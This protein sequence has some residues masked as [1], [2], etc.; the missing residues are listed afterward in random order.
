MW[1]AKKYPDVWQGW[2]QALEVQQAL[3]DCSDYIKMAQKPRKIKVFRG[4]PVS[5]ALI[6]FG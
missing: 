5:M 6:L 2:H 4:F 1:K 3:I